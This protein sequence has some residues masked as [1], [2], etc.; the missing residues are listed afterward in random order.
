MDAVEME[1]SPDPGGGNGE[2]PLAWRVEPRRVLPDQGGAEEVPGREVPPDAGG[3]SELPPPVPVPF[4][5]SLTRIYTCTF[6]EPGTFTVPV[7]F[8]G[9][10]TVSVTFVNPRSNS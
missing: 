8:P 1:V 2:P 4:T 3:E 7:P 10:V 5:E 6:P 9:V